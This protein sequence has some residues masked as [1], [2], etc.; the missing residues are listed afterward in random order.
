MKLTYEASY[1]SIP[2]RLT[3]VAATPDMPVIVY[4]FGKDQTQTVNYV[5]ITIADSEV[6]FSPFGGNDYRQQDPPCA[7]HP[8]SVARAGSTGAASAR[9]SSSS[10]PP[11]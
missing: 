3:A 1:P 4:I 7:P 8:S 6:R 9:H 5:P 11:T 10:T 2:L